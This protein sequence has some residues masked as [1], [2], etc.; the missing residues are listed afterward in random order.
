MF[1][2]ADVVL[3]NKVDLLPHLR[4]DLHGCLGYMRQV[5][6]ALQVIP[7]S[8]QRGDGLDMW[9]AWLRAWPSGREP[10]Q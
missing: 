2:A 1:R 3:P 7:V 4:F 10:V 6:T 8:A 5:N 9:Y